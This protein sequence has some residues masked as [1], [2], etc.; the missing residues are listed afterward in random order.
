MS[1]EGQHTFRC[2]HIVNRALKNSLED[3]T[4]IPQIEQI[5]EFAG[6]G[7]QL[8]P[9]SLV[10]VKSG[11]DDSIR[12]LLHIFRKDTSIEETFK[13]RPEYLLEVRIRWLWQAQNHMVSGVSLVQ[14]ISTSTRSGPTSNYSR[15]DDLLPE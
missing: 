14:P 15:I 9:N 1:P 12:N 10:K 6:N 4:N 7:Q 2:T 5:M 3:S 8:F 11:Q 13:D